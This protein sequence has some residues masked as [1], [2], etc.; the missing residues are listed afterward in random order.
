MKIFNFYNTIHIE[1]GAKYIDNG[2]QW[3]TRNGLAKANI[4]GFMDTF[5]KCKFNKNT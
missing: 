1:K 4:N 5:T 2:R 3:L